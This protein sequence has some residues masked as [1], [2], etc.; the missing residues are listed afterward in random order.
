M[1]LTQRLAAMDRREKERDEKILKW[2][3]ENLKGKLKK[4]DHNLINKIKSGLMSLRFL[5]PG[6][7]K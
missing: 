5:F 6:D 7:G 2:S 1:N 3:S 4:S